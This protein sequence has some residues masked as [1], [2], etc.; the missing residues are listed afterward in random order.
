[1]IRL[2]K[3]IADTR[4]LTRK[5]A[6]SLIRAGRV[7]V[8]G[9]TVRDAAAK[10]DEARCTVCVDGERVGYAAHLYVML[11][12]P[13]GLLS[14]SVDAKAPTVLS[15]LPAEYAAKGVACV[16]RL[17]KDTVG[18]LLLTNDG[19]LSHRLTSPKSLVKKGY[20]VRCDKPFC[21]ADIAVVRDGI[22]IDGKRTAPAALT[23]TDDP[24][25]AEMVL[26]EGKFHEVKRLCYA[27]GGKEVV[28]LERVTFGPLVLDGTLDRGA[29]RSLSADEV[30]LLGAL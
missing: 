8:D 9:F 7:T 16:G 20:R 23:L 4:V 3:Y 2:D 26:T 10:I 5:D 28:F 13:A 14:A 22:L 27:C 18:L 15:L 30:A 12:K 1:M 6:V 17:D 24:Y 11:N 29:W 21:E 19:A 25:E